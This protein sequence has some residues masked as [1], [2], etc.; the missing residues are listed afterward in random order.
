LDLLFWRGLIIYSDFPSD[1]KIS[2]VSKKVWLGIIY[3]KMSVFDNFGG[4]TIVGG[5]ALS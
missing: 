1:G 4:K 5:N 2:S 3:S